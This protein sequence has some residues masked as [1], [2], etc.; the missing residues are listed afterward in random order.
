VSS[1][2]RTFDELAVGWALH[3]LEPEDEAVFAA[4]L[5][6]CDR[7][8]RTVAETVE[9]MASLATDLPLAE[10]S[11]E[12][13]HRLSDAVRQTEQVRTGLSAGWSPAALGLP[14]F[15]DAEFP[16][17]PA[18]PWHR[19]LPTLLAAAALAVI[20][21]LGLWNVVLN[22][23][24]QQAEA[25]ARDQTRILSSV[26]TPGQ[27]TIAPLANPAGHTVAT[28]VARHHQ[29]QVITHGLRVNNA[30]QSTY[31]VWGIRPDKAVALGTFDVV[32]TQIDLRTV[33][34]S[35]IALADFP[36][37]GISLERGRQAPS[38]PTDIVATGEVTS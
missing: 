12:L 7:C 2:H 16:G 19:A 24:R 17:P 35:P 10:P 11:A 14:D 21:A 33:G 26:L 5:A 31:V 22:E 15:D 38:A 23:S 36:S 32:H 30:A 4:H 27:A 34:S 8:A 20:V 37:Y 28:V 29:V 25:T 3:A 13:R 9:V 1:E 6:D 18:P